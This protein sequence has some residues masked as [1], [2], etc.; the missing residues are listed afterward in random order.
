MT[1]E[2]LLGQ[3][4]ELEE[5]AA[6]SIVGRAAQLKEAGFEMITDIFGID[7]L[8]YTRHQGK[9]FSVTYCFSRADGSARHHLRA[10]PSFPR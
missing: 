3:T 7:W 8:E 4:D 5:V 6:A 9:R 10:A 1:P 2:L